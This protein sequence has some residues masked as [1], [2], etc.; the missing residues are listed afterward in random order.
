M[1]E[2]FDCD[3]VVS[4]SQ[5]LGN[6]FGVLIIP[7]VAGE[8]GFPVDVRGEAIVAGGDQLGFLNFAG[9]Q[10]KGFTEIDGLVFLGSVR[11]DPLRGLRRNQHGSQCQKGKQNTFHHQVVR[12]K[13][14][15][16][17]AW[18]KAF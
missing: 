9:G 8:G 3:D 5:Q 10:V 15:Y 13:L 11:P 7:L 12:G 4:C 14:V 6:V 1:I 17:T 2:A 18:G 16:R